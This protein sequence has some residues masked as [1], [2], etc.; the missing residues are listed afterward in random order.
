[1]DIEY[2]ENLP[3]KTG[4][5]R[6]GKARMEGLSEEQ[7]S[8]L[9]KSGAIARWSKSAAPVA[10]AICGSDERP[11]VIGGIIIPCYV[12]ED[13]VRVIT[14]DGM[15][16]AL[17]VQKRGNTPRFDELLAA[18]EP[19]SATGNELAVKLHSPLKF[20]TVSDARKVYRGYQASLLV[21]VCES[22]LD[23]R[24]VGTLPPRLLNLGARAELLVRGLARVGID[25]LIDEAT[26][27][28]NFRSKNALLELLHKYISDKLLQWAKTFPDE[29][30]SELFR[31]RNLPFPSGRVPR[32]QFFGNLTND[33]VYRRLAP[34][35]LEE[36][37]RVAPRNA[38]GKRSGKLFQML[39][40]SWGYRKLLE[41]MGAVITM[42]Q[43][44]T[45]Y[46]DFK[47]TIDRL[48][49][50]YGT[51]LPLPFAPGELDDDNGVGL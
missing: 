50:V 28:Q 29:F 8:A 31:L 42:M 22:V 18:I 44:S 46:E 7:R 34:G 11:L 51:T 40:A 9:G 16:S 5:H 20:T 33:I 48:R 30:Y 4:K 2:N 35:V 32:P 47:R 21:D 49:P 6:S 3:E 37:K 19:N 15:R 27:F 14:L 1:M 43:L 26:G 17:D 41:H 36:L 23:A 13:E 38:K 25:A 10:R 12:L 39:S 45:K 24:R